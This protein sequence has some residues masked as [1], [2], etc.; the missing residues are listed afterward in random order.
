MLIPYLLVAVVF[1]PPKLH[2][3]KEVVSDR[4]TVDICKQ[5]VHRQIENIL[6]KIAEKLLITGSIDTATQHIQSHKEG[7]HPL[8]QGALL[9]ATVCFEIIKNGKQTYNTNYLEA[10]G[11]LN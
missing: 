10:P 7:V 8:W 1:L 11:R 6:W 9:E 5:L 3:A 2:Q 4:T